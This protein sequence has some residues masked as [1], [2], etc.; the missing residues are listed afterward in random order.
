M[1]VSAL[2]K[3]IQVA[4]QPFRKKVKA[5][6]QITFVGVAGYIIVAI[7]ILFYFFNGSWPFNVMY[8]ESMLLN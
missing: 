6:H 2:L 3:N 1:T 5:Q 8:S 7:L 4:V